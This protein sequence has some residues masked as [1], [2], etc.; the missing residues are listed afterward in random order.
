[1]ADERLRDIERAA[2]SGDLNALARLRRERERT[3][4][5]IPAVHYVPEDNH[6]Q[7]NDD[8]TFNLD[9]QRDRFTFGVRFEVRSPC[10]VILWPRTERTFRKVCR[11]TSDP[12]NVTCKTCLRSMAKPPVRKVIRRHYAPGSR[13][14]RHARPVCEKSDPNKYKESFHYTM[15]EVNC[16]ICM[17]IMQRG[18][19][20]R[21]R[22]QR[23]LTTLMDELHALG[24]V[25]GTS[26]EPEF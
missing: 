17:R 20:K 15:K 4:T 26:D 24:L 21:R 7:L 2:R 13:D 3:G 16:P 23:E 9:P 18:R 14:G 8:G 11:F 19:H 5:L 22:P 1:M 10:N 25:P 6:I 12:I